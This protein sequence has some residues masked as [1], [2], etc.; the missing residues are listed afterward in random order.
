MIRRFVFWLLIALLPLQCVHAADHWAETQV[1]AQHWLEHE[2]G[3]SHHHDD[4][5]TVHHDESDASQEHM[6]DHVGC[7][8]NGMPQVIATFAL[9]RLPQGPPAANALTVRPDPFLDKPPRPPH[10]LG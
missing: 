9:P 2:Q 4:D 3:V 8:L 10:S 6:G 1:D 5:G 7:H